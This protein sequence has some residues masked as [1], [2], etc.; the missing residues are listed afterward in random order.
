M[1]SKRPTQ[2]RKDLAP[3]S[4][5]TGGSGGTGSG[6]QGGD[7]KLAVNE[8]LTLVRGVKPSKKRDLPARKDVTGGKKK[9]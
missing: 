8:N 6:G 3:K 2:K 5:V 1:G 7:P 4:G 9:V